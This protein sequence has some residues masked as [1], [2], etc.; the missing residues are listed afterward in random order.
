MKNFQRVPE[1]Y[2]EIRLLRDDL[3]KHAGF[4]I[5]SLSSRKLL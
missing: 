5:T 3:G 4:M 1:I 2:E